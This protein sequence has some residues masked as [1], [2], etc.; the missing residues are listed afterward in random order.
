MSIKEQRSFKKELFNELIELIKILDG[1]SIIFFLDK[2]RESINLDLNN[3][4]TILAIL[5]NRGLHEFVKYIL[6]NINNVNPNST[7]NDKLTPLFLAFKNDKNDKNKNK[8]IQYLLFHPTIDIKQ[9]L[10]IA[11]NE[12]NHDFLKFLLNLEK[13]NFDDNDLNECINECIYSSSPSEECIK[14]ILEY[15]KFVLSDE[16]IKNAFLFKLS[17]I[18]LL[19]L[20]NIHDMMYLM[21]FLTLACEHILP[22]V[23]SALLLCSDID[24]S[25]IN[26]EGKSLIAIVCSTDHESHESIDILKSLLS[27]PRFLDII[28]SKDRYQRTALTIA[29]QHSNNHM[30]ELLLDINGIDISGALAK[31]CEKNNIDAIKLLL[32]HPD[33]NVNG[34][35]SIGTHTPLETACLYGREGKGNV[36]SVELLLK[37][38]GIVITEKAIDMAIQNKSFRCFDLLLEYIIEKARPLV[39]RKY[40]IYIRCLFIFILLKAK[41]DYKKRN[42]SNSLQIVKL[43]FLHIIMKIKQRS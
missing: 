18:I 16:N 37:H 10:L 28:N 15:K 23:V 32:G 39:Q 12:G 17:S 9:N 25:I 38:P 29:C 8:C 14:T 43:L 34:L 11:C 7:D 41:E 40:L 36:I 6:E 22:P 30:A 24:A 13:Y 20:T 35:N 2:N 26:D 27:D 19:F 3:G 1:K 5:C 31:C 21:M 33:V 42:I 4:R